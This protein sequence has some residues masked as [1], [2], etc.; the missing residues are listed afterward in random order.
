MTPDEGMGWDLHRRRRRR[1]RLHAFG[2]L[3]QITRHGDHLFSTLS[4][5]IMYFKSLKPIST[6]PSDQWH[7]QRHRPRGCEQQTASGAWE[8]VCWQSR[9][10]GRGQL[11]PVRRPSR[12]LLRDCLTLTPG[13]GE[14]MSEMGGVRDCLLLSLAGLREVGIAPAQWIGFC[15]MGRRQVW[16]GMEARGYIFTRS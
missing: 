16:D 10:R 1:H 11:R 14:G 12:L 15:G 4:Y 3:Q 6:G 2:I 13:A 5:D 7:W 9:S 8:D